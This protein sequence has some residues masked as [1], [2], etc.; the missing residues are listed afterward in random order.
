MIRRLLPF[1][2][3]VFAFAPLRASADIPPW[4]GSAGQVSPLA[5]DKSLALNLTATAQVVAIS[6]TTA[7]SVCGFAATATGT[8]PTFQFEYG[9]GTVCGTGTVVLS[10]ALAPTT[11]SFV[12]Y[13]SGLGAIFQTPAAQAL[14][15]VV[16]G[17]T[18][19][20]QGVLSYAQR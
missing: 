7:I 2:L 10:G 12:A 16:G 6:G 5:C 14:C 15:I 1:V 20:V 9:T 13:G 17:T 4:T 18:P 11:G 8:T 3:F 19:S